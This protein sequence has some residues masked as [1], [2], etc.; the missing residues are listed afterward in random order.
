MPVRTL[1][2]ITLIINWNRYR[3]YLLT[4]LNER[5]TLIQGQGE[6][7]ERPHLGGERWQLAAHQIKDGEVGRLHRQVRDDNKLVLELAGQ[8]FEVGVG[9]GP[10]MG[11]NQGP[12]GAPTSRLQPRQQLSQLGAVHVVLSVLVVHCVVDVLGLRDG[13]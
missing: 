10:D 7:G 6:V 1:L 11:D 12:L 3:R 8:Q 9:G 4:N 2:T 5:L 13:N